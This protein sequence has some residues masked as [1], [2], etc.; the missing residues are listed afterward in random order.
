[1]AQQPL[2]LFLCTAMWGGGGGQMLRLLLGGTSGTR[3]I[4]LS[5]CM[6]FG[7]VAK[8]EACL[9]ATASCF[10][11]C[12]NSRLPGGSD[13]SAPAHGPMG[14]GRVWWGLCVV[15]VCSVRHVRVVIVPAGLCSPSLC[16]PP[17]AQ[18]ACCWSLSGAP[19]C[20]FRCCALQCLWL[21][22]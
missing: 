6:R 3:K 10:W 11:I 5:C 20:R 19:A 16:P 9:Y 14:L 4:A 18:Q 12:Y 22:Q 8:G 17:W 15:C 21:C 7:M 2:P 13:E 1:M